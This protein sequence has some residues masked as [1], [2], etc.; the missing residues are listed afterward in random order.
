MQVYLVGPHDKKENLT[1][2]IWWNRG[3]I[4]IERFNNFM[5]KIIYATCCFMQ[6]AKSNNI[7][8]D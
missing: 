5:T 8:A 6:T 7:I 2:I 3:V 1:D 4:F